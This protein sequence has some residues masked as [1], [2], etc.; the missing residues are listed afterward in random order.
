LCA[1]LGLA[2]AKQMISIPRRPM[3]VSGKRMVIKAKD[4][5]GHA[6]HQAVKER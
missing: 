6:L 1:D 5:V 3:V 2:A 4:L